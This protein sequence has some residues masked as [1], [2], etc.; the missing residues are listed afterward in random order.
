MQPPVTVDAGMPASEAMAIAA[1]TQADLL[2]VTG[3]EGVPVGYLTPEAILAR[4]PGRGSADWNRPAGSSGLIQPGP[5]TL[6]EPV[7]AS[8]I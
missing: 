7:T 2:I 3:P 5:G 1:R 8:T 4:A 6:L